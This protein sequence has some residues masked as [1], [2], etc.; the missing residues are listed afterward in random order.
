MPFKN[1]WVNGRI[2]KS[3]QA[4]LLGQVVT[5]LLEDTRMVNF[6]QGTYIFTDGRKD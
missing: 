3:G 2:V 1:T 4:P 6:G 5:N